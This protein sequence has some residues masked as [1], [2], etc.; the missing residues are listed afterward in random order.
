M[1]ILAANIKNKSNR[2]VHESQPFYHQNN[3]PVCG[4]HKCKR[5]TS[6]H[7]LTYQTAT[8]VRINKK[9]YTFQKSPHINISTY[10]QEISIHVGTYG[11]LLSNN[12]KQFDDIVCL[13]EQEPHL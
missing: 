5:P 12:T 3:V 4:K 11:S 1:L 13:S 2:V 9:F 7:I 10:F 8:T 6:I